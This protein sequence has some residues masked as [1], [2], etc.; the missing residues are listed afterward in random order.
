MPEHGTL[1]DAIFTSFYYLIGLSHTDK[2][3]HV[4]FLWALKSEEWV[5]L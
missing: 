3:F 5:S 2:Y 1:K 4:G